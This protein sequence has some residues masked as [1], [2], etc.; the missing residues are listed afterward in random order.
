MD[1]CSLLHSPLS[2]LPPLSSKLIK[3]MKSKEYIDLNTLLPN[4]LYDTSSKPSYNLPIDPGR[5]GDATVSLTQNHRYTHKISNLISW[6]EAWNVFI[7]SMVNS[8]PQLAPDFLAYQENFCSLTRTYTFQSCYKYEVAFCMNVARNN[9]LSWSQL[10][11]YAFNRFLRCAAPTQPKSFTCFKCFTPGHL[12]ADCPSVTQSSM[13]RHA[14]HGSATHNPHLF[15]SRQSMP[16]PPCRHYNG[17]NCDTKSC[18]WPHIC[19][20]CGGPHP[21]ADCP[22]ANR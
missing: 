1:I 13:G 18:G 7:R 20:R 9:L 17:R 11:E 2:S 12:V 14:P 21:G 10:D 5:E 6:L 15:H 3:S 19:N 22:G 4:V 16:L 8:H